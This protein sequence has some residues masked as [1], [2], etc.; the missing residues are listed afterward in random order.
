MLKVS[1][2]YFQPSFSKSLLFSLAT[3]YMTFA[4]YILIYF[5]ESRITSR[6]SILAHFLTTCPVHRQLKQP[7]ATQIMDF[8]FHIL[9]HS[10]FIGIVLFCAEVTCYFV[11]PHLFETNDLVVPRGWS[12]FVFP[13]LFDPPAFSGSNDDIPWL[14]SLASI[15]VLIFSIVSLMFHTSRDI[16]WATIRLMFS[17]ILFRINRHPYLSNEI[18]NALSQQI[19]TLSLSYSSLDSPVFMFLFPWMFNSAF[20]C[21]PIMVC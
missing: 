2:N 7:F 8:F 16:F 13:T 4:Y 6:S 15:S 10:A 19:C 12:V 11:E 5:F 9:Y 3:E 18:P 17:G 21:V 20:M 1:K 14:R